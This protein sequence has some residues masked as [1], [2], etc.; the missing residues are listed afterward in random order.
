MWGCMVGCVWVRGCVGLWF[1]VF[2]CRCVTVCGCVFVELWVRVSEGPGFQDFGFQS[3]R[4][5]GMK[6]EI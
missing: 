5:A 4:V 3:F 2:L 6:Y 1:L